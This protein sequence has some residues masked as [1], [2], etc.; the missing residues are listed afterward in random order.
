M[1]TSASRL[2]LCVAV[3][4]VAAGCGVNDDVSEVGQELGGPSLHLTYN[5]A[6]HNTYLADFTPGPNV[7][8]HFSE[9]KG[10]TL[11]N[12][13]PTYNIEIDLRDTI[14][15]SVQNH[16]ETKR[17]DGNWFVAHGEASAPTEKCKSN[18]GSGTFIDCLKVISAWHYAHPD[19][20]LLTIW[21]DK[22]QGWESDK[23]TERSPSRM[24]F[25]LNYYFGSALYI[26]RMRSS[27]T[28]YP[29]EFVAKNK[30]PS[31]S[32]LNG[33]VMFVMTS[34]SNLDGNARL[35]EYVK[36][37]SGDATV[38][39]AP[40]ADSE[41]NVVSRPDSFTPETAAWVAIYDFEWSSGG[42]EGDG[43]CDS[44]LC[45]YVPTA[46]SLN[47]LTRLYDIQDADEYDFAS[48]KERGT[49]KYGYAN[50][51]PVDYAWR[52]G[53]NGENDDSAYGTYVNGTYQH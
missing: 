1:E 3:G 11:E 18:D 50:F 23:D 24:D 42:D 10:E 30:W 9:H 7:D 44:S 35:S 13:P 33:K 8:W 45:F 16:F 27:G 41:S 36:L 22:K 32:D 47:Y 28:T 5:K 46:H 2:R 20:H 51:I 31:L 40:Y 48:G 26:P 15:K 4:L 29:H 6:S 49:S 25:L 21:L 38:W 17:L 12:S 14:T 39:V 37:R 19:H 53:T 43:E 34:D 52:R